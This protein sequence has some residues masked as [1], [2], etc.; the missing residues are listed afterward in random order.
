MKQ[1]VLGKR[2]Y[3]IDLAI[4][5]VKMIHKITKKYVLLNVIERQSL[6]GI[7]KLFQPVIERIVVIITGF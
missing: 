2:F 3:A 6:E 4:V 7:R 5:V 1:S